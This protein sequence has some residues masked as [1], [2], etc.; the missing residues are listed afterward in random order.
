MRGAKESE[1][2]GLSM[3][4]VRLPLK[5]LTIDKLPEHELMLTS[6]GLY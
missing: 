2:L 6:T 5:P 4:E 3:S 1:Y